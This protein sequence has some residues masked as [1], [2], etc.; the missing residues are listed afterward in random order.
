ML[1]KPNRVYSGESIKLMS[2]AIKKFPAKQ[3]GVIIIVVLLLISLMITLLAFMVEKQ[4][5]LVRR[6]TNQNISEQGFQYAQGMNAW[7]QRVLHD[8]QDRVVDYLDE[9]WAKFGRPEEVSEEAE[10]SFSL[11]LSSKQEEEEQPEIDFGIDGLEVSI[12]DLQARYNLNNIGVIEPAQ[13]AN[14]KIIFL[15]LL[16]VLEV[17]DL[18]QREALYGALLDWIDENDLANT[19]SDGNSESGYYQVKPTPYYAADQKLTSL[20]ELRFVEGFTEEVINTLKPYVTALPVDNAK[21]N[22][23]TASEEVLASL[24]GATPVVDIASVT[25]FLR[26]RE[27]DGFLGFQPGDIQAAGNA[28]IGVNPVREPAFVDM[29]QVNS[30]FFK[31]N[32]KVALGDFEYCMKTIVLRE[33]SASGGAGGVNTTSS[34]PKVSVLNRQYDTLCKDEKP[35][36]A[37]DESDEDVS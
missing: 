18:A 10:E 35:V 19:S 23:N 2:Y 4:H 5:V 9:D 15:N 30:L 16:G 21:I 7:A 27:E 14:Q 17:G 12:D 24:S 34:A 13:R 22:I 3:S 31:I 8:D 36:D 25:D 6:I 37:V 29:M 33:A 28:I 20:G 32:V 11:D 26:V 1:A